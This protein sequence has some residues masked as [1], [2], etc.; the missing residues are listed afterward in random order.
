MPFDQRLLNSPS[1]ADVAELARNSVLERRRLLSTYRRLRMGIG[2]K[3]VSL[4]DELEQH[5]QTAQ[6]VQRAFETRRG[7]F[8]SN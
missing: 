7:Q 6:G 2:L 4:Y 8:H 1:P 5:A 3:N